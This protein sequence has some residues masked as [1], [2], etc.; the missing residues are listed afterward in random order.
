[1]N[2]TSAALITY[3]Y[4]HSP[5]SQFAIAQMQA[6]TQKIVDDQNYLLN[7]NAYIWSQ[8]QDLIDITC[9]QSHALNH[10]DKD[11]IYL[12][13]LNQAVS[14][15]AAPGE[16]GLTWSLATNKMNLILSGAREI[17]S[18]NAQLEMLLN[19][20]LPVTNGYD[21]APSYIVTCNDLNGLFG[22]S[23]LTYL[24]AAMLTIHLT[25]LGDNSHLPAAWIDQSAITHVTP[26]PEKISLDQLDPNFK[27][28]FSYFYSDEYTPQGLAFVHSGYAFGGQR[29]EDRYQPA[30]KLYG[31]E[32]CSSWLAKIV[33]SDISFSTIDMLYAFRMA[34][35]ESERGYIDQNWLQSDYAQITHFI[36]PVFIN[37]INQDIQPGLIWVARK[38]EDNV[39]HQSSSGKSGHTALVLGLEDNGEEVLTIG[40]HRNMPEMEGF[41]LRS[42]P[43][44]ADTNT[45]VMY[46]SIN[47]P[48]T[49]AIQDIFSS[50]SHDIHP[51]SQ[52]PFLPQAIN[53][54]PLIQED[55]VLL[56]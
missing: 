30:G 54:M 53:I 31:P 21:N 42:F 7:K 14:N 28:H 24:S 34:Q 10:I 16:Y 18:D 39:D 38:F 1:M 19:G 44:V 32:D 17:I 23:Q 26:I 9:F 5:V 43:A 25:L 20:H 27:T 3:A 52:A 4:Q 13:K 6:Y 8:T 11:L 56:L 15:Y 47:H 48:T 12:E 46:F 22:N 37:D 45:E 2:K 29:D 36:T 49:L 40:Y 55:L 33:Q 50:S 51:E 35:P 41:G